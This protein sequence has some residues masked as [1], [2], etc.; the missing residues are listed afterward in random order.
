ML[1]LNAAERK[2]KLVE[3]GLVPGIKQPEYERRLKKLQRTHPTLFSQNDS[4]NEEKS[5]EASNSQEP[6]QE[7]LEKRLSLVESSIQSLQQQ[8]RQ[9]NKEL[10]LSYDKRNEESQTQFSE[11]SQPGLETNCNNNVK[12]KSGCHSPVHDHYEHNDSR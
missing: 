2:R 4:K 8:L 3:L 11:E 7:P 6:F 5:N 12:T 1:N 10:N 9:V